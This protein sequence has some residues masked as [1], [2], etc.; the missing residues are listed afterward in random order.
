MDGFY[1]NGFGY[2]ASGEPDYYTL[3]QEQKTKEARGVF[4]RCHLSL[5]LYLLI[6]S[7]LVFIAE[8]ALIAVLGVEGYDA[9]MTEHSYISVIFGFAPSYLIGFPILYLLTRK[10]KTAPMTKRKMPISEFLALFLIAE[11]AMT[12]GSL[13]GEAF[14][15]F[16]STIIQKEVIDYTS[17]LIATSSPWLILPIA[18]VVGPIIEELIFRKI[19][20][21]RFARFGYGISIVVTAFAFALFHCNFYQ[22]FYAFF[23]GLILGY[24]Y[25]RTRNV[26]YPMIMHMLVNFLGTVA[27][28]PVIGR[29]AEFTK[30]LEDIM[31]GLEVDMASF[32]ENA[33]IV[34]SY[35]VIMYALLGGGIAMLI[36]YIKK[37]K[38]K[39]PG[40]WEYQIPKERRSNVVFVNPGTIMFF[41]LA[42]SLV[43]Y[44]IIL[45]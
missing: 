27:T 45:V 4:S 31:N 14:N 36:T 8:L 25:A 21:D 2:D 40:A 10:M 18:V 39:I 20:F 9:F 33:M 13:I 1:N 6:P 11:L 12:V 24:V 16:I 26:I 38:F 22:F 3:Y 30:Q 32:I 37:R 29:E 5:F 44:S 34:G 28:L 43:L 17:E 41:A 15:G 35:S 19:F 7:A 23:L 42:I